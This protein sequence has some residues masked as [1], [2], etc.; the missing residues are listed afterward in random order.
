M[1]MKILVER[2]ERGVIGADIRG[3]RRAEIGFDRGRREAGQAQGSCGKNESSAE[4]GIH[5]APRKLAGARDGV[6]PF[7]SKCGSKS[8][9]DNLRDGC[10]RPVSL[11]K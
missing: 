10:D 3:H 2:V 4:V 8:L 1:A 6:R 7:R 5:E 11:I 9:R